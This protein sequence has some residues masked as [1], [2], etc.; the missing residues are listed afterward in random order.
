M[1]IAEIGHIKF[2]LASLKD[3][4]ALLKI[5]GDAK[6]VDWEYVGHDKKYY[7]TEG[8]CLLEI[9]LKAGNV[10]S[11]QEFEVLK[12]QLKAPKSKEKDNA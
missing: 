4:E 5:M 1:I 11:K 12:S 10:T 2:E 6:P 8:E 9:S 7:Y 3:S